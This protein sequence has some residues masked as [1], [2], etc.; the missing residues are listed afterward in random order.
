MWNIVFGVIAIVGGLS[1]KLALLGTNSPKALVGVGVV[2]VGIGI[3]QLAK[4]N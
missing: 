4:K 1:G 2:F 3:Y